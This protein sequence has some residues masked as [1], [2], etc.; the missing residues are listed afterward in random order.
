METLTAASKDIRVSGHT[1][2]P[3][4]ARDTYLSL[5]VSFVGVVF[6]QAILSVMPEASRVHARSVAVR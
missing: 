2:V 1:I 3:R 4:T 5:N 6:P